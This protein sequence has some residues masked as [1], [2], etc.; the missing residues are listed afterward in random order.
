MGTLYALFGHFVHTLWALSGYY[1]DTTRILCDYSVG[2]LWGRT[3][4]LA[5]RG[6]SPHM[7]MRFGIVCLLRCGLLIGFALNVHKIIWSQAYNRYGLVFISLVFISLVF[8][9]LL[10][11]YLMFIGKRLGRFN[12]GGFAGRVQSG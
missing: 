2:T 12:V 10:F 3:T 6:K 5:Q 8:I 1:V 9:Y 4:E 11:I 7:R